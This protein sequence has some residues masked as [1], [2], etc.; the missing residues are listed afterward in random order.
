MNSSITG[1]IASM[2]LAANAGT[3]H[4]ADAATAA[5]APLAMMRL[6]FLMFNLPASFSFPRKQL[7]KESLLADEEKDQADKRERLGHGSANEEVAHKLTL[8]FGLAGS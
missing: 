5:N 8:H 6:P 7:S 1:M 4:K 2:P 3:G